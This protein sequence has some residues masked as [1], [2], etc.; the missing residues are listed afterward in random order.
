MKKILYLSVLFFTFW[1]SLA[2]A[3]QDMQDSDYPQ[4]GVGLS[5][6]YSQSGL[7]LGANAVFY[8]HTVPSG[9]ALDTIGWGGNGADYLGV[10]ATIGYQFNPYVALQGDY[11][12]F[13]SASGSGYYIDSTFINAP[14]HYD[15][16]GGDVLLKGILPLGTRFALNGFGG[17][18]I[19]NENAYN[20][21]YPGI[22]PLVNSDITNAMPEIGAG[23][24]VYLMRWLS[25][26]GSVFY[27]FKTGQINSITSYPVSLTVHF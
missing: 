26:D 17:V 4:S 5:T 8:T 11:I 7:Y 3:N 22:P 21:I 24:S 12:Y 16:Q 2:V 1:A 19:I 10:G 15:L 14:D 13:D 23:V 9:A 25:L 27:A 6:T 20:V 18:A